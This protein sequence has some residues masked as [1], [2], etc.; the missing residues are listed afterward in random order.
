MSYALFEAEA[1]PLPSAERKEEDEEEDKNEK[2]GVKMVLEN[3]SS[4][5]RC[6]REVIRICRARA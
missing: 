6:S 5:G 4:F 1:I 2:K 3:R